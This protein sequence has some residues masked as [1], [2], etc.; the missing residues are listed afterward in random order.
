V[1]DLIRDWPESARLLGRAREVTPGGVHSNVR[2]L[3]VPQPLF[4]AHG[5]GA[6]ITD[7][8]GNV[9]L[10]YVLGQ[11]PLIHGHGHPELV[12]AAEAGLRR[13]MMFAG[14]HPGEVLLAE[15]I[16]R[17]VPCAQRVRLCGAGSEAVQAA[18]R[19]ARHHTGRP[20]YLKFEGHYHGWYDNVLI[21]V[22]PP[23]DAA[24]PREAPNVVPGTPGT[25]PG[26][27][28]D[29]LVLPWNDADLLERTLRAHAHELAAVIT[30]P[31]MGNV[32]C[33]LPRAGFLQTLRDLC[34]QL[35]IVLIFDEVITG[36]R[37]APGGAQQHFGVTP[38]LATFGKAMAGGFPIACLAGRADLMDALARGVNHAGTYNAS[39]LVVE[40]TRACLDLLTRDDGAAYRRLYDLAGLLREG[41]AALAAEAGVAVQLQG[42]G[43]MFHLAFAEQ[44]LTDYRTA[45]GADTRRYHRFTEALLRRGVRV[46]E[47]GL[48][49][50]S[51]AHTEADIAETLAAARAALPE[52][53]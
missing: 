50:V 29:V 26:A 27:H 5:E 46:L 1:A 11:G 45:L 2:L 41:L 21:S 3:A 18:L 53:A 19:L 9:Y 33:V 44:P 4:F 32:G 35:G 47:R 10:D 8:D 25:A 28:R 36:F 37:L 43:P 30:E 42:V 7:V 34:T 48:W 23:L 52:S 51:T 49:Y 16:C 39:P 38:D 31:V 14:Q 22:A 6:R 24:G 40:A 13:G 20:K 15:E 12:A 17:L